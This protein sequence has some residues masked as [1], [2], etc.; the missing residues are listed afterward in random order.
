MNAH[1]I[2]CIVAL[3]FAL[4]KNICK[5]PF[6][7]LSIIGHLVHSLFT[8]LHYAARYGHSVTAE[9]ICI[10]HKILAPED[11]LSWINAVDQYAAYTFS[12]P[13]ALD[14]PVL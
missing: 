10:L 5:I 3:R 4:L 9:R 7:V 13:L 6:I 2:W 14:L 8:P 11:H 1:S 12:F